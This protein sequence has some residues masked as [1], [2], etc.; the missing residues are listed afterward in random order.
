MSVEVSDTFTRSLRAGAHCPQAF[1]YKRPKTP[2]TASKRGFGRSIKKLFF[3]D[4]NGVTKYYISI[5]VE[6][7]FF[8]NSFIGFRIHCSPNFEGNWR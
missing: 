2:K 6:C 5:I 7:L 8:A 1:F 4:L 3:F